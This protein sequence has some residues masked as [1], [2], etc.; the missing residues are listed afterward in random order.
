M[1]LV[2]ANI[3]YLTH[4]AIREAIPN[5]DTFHYEINDTIP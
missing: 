3:L 1:T 4:S 2:F 5:H